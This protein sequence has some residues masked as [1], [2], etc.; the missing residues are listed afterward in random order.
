M[1]S[2]LFHNVGNILTVVLG[3]LIAVLLSSGCTQLATGGFE[4]SAS[5]IDP[6]LTA[7]A[8]MGVAG[9]KLAVNI[10]RDGV[11]GLFKAQP[12]VV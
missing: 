3:G 9:L 5:W 10:V 2:N 4:C 11:G 7:F 1:N 8:I 6:K 12:P